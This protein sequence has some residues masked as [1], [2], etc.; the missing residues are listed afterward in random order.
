MKDHF[1]DLITYADILIEAG[2]ILLIAIAI[3]VINYRPTN[4][5]LDE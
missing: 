4:K 5:L 1:K 2:A 3:L